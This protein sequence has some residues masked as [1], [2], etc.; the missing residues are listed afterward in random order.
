RAD[1]HGET[2]DSN[3]KVLHLSMSRP[4][5]NNLSTETK[6]LGYAHWFQ[7]TRKKTR[8]VLD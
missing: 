2:G 6:G 5:F 8:E 3:S 4:L 7:I 1:K